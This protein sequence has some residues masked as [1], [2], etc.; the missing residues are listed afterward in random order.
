[1]THDRIDCLFPARISTCIATP[2][3]YEAP[4]WEEEL[5]AIARSVPKRRREFSAGRAA[6]RC[7]LNTLGVPPGPIPANADR[8]PSW[9]MGFVGSISHCDNFCAA[10]VGCSDDVAGVGFDVETVSPLSPEIADLIYDDEEAAHFSALPEATGYEWGKLAFSAKEAFYK[11]YF[12][13]VRSF[14]DFR[15]V[16]VSFSHMDASGVG[17]FAISIKDRRKPKVLA[18]YEFFGRWFAEGDFI[19]TGTMLMATR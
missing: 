8:T 2:D 14:L 17:E 16:S 13:K 11:C 6:A 3:M 10:V 9:P 18:G 4:L 7:A 1:M 12:P 15:D 19:C 5:E